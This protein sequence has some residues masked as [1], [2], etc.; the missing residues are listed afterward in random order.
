MTDLEIT[1]RC[2]EAMGYTKWSAHHGG[3][4]GFTKETGIYDPLHDKAQAFELLILLLNSGHRTVLENNAM[5][6]K[7]YGKAPI[8]VFEDDAV[9]EI[10]TVDLLMRAICLCVASM[11][12]PRKERE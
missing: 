7:F 3:L 5:A 6:G 11:Q 1:R 4:P 8:L 2:A 10:E 12:Q 9:H